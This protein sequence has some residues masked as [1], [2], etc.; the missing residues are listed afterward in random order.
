MIPIYSVRS[1]STA[2]YPSIIILDQYSFTKI[3]TDSTKIYTK[4]Y[5]VLIHATGKAA[6]MPDNKRD[7]CIPH[8]NSRSLAGCNIS[9]YGFYP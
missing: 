6:T 5:G 1:T 8:S 3:I 4:D 2:R 7:Q 9:I